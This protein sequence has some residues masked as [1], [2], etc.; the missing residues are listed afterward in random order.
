M[1]FQ[2]R[3]TIHKKEHQNVEELDLYVS[4]NTRLDDP[5]NLFVRLDDVINQKSLIYFYA[6]S[7]GKKKI[8]IWG[9]YDRNIN[10]FLI[11]DACKYKLND[12]KNILE[13]WKSNQ[14]QFLSASV[15]NSYSSRIYQDRIYQ[16]RKQELILLENFKREFLKGEY[17]FDRVSNDGMAAL[18]LDYANKTKLYDPLLNLF[19]NNIDNVEDEIKFR[20]ILAKDK[21]TFSKKNL[22]AKLVLA[23]IFILV[24]ADMEEY[25]VAKYIQFLFNKNKDKNKEKIQKYLNKT[26]LYQWL[27]FLINQFNISNEE[28]F[29]NDYAFIVIDLTE[30]NI[31]TTNGIIGGD[32]KL[33][34]NPD[35]TEMSQFFE[36][37]ISKSKYSKI[38]LTNNIKECPRYEECDMNGDETCALYNFGTYISS[39]YD[40]T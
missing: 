29:L 3:E 18:V 22:K 2:V 6:Y 1:Q 12:L 34:N 28:K 17:D 8:V 35:L 16:D 24:F 9:V 32:N 26:F 30:K 4:L 39:K 36:E 5:Y 14:Y 37:F 33:L 21:I 25:R 15:K 40:L 20:E 38:T 7:L 31:N 27:L 19:Y 13:T 11:D 23:S 10:E